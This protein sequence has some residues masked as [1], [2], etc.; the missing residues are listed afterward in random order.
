MCGRFSTGKIPLEFLIE[1]FDLPQVDQFEEQYNIAPTLQ[2]PVI[3]ER[4][5]GRYFDYLRWGLIP[6]WSKDKGT[7]PLINARIETIAEKPS[8]KDSFRRRRCIIPACGFYEWER[9]GKEK[10]PYYIFQADRKPMTLAGLWDS[11]TN[12]ETGEVIESCTI[13]TTESIPMLEEL[14]DRMPVA[15]NYHSAKK[16]LDMRITD[17]EE[18]KEILEEGQGVQLEM[19]PVSLYV[20]SVGNEGEKCVERVDSSLSDQ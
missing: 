2:I 6:S 13:I 16:W 8:F 9:V 4:E 12:R 15:L 7:A 10:Q 5:G 20:N 18:L 3:R 1:I 14:H 11:W 19:Y 17:T